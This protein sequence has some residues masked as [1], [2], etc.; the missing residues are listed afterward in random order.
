MSDSDCGRADWRVLALD[1]QSTVLRMIQAIITLTCDGNTL[2]DVRS[3][4]AS[5]RLYGLDD[6]TPLLDGGHATVEAAPSASIGDTI[7][8]VALFV[9]DTQALPSDSLVEFGSDICVDLVVRRVTDISC[10][11]HIGE[12]PTNILVETHPLCGACE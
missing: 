3:F 9:T 2:E 10:G 7:G 11:S 6:T 5:A 1:A 8:S 4:V 12:M